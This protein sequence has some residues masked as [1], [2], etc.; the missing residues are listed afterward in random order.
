M[1]LSATKTMK[2]S[3]GVDSNISFNAWSIVGCILKSLP[4]IEQ[5]FD[6]FGSWKCSGYSTFDWKGL[7]DDFICTYLMIMN[8]FG[9]KKG[10]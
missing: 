9:E 4:I 2:A 5:Y 1:S 10:R 7:S 8:R 3:S 6:P